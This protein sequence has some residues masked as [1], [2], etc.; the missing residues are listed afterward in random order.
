[1]HCCAAALSNQRRFI[2]PSDAHVKA[3]DAGVVTHSIADVVETRPAWAVANSLNL[4][5][6][7]RV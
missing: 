4:T 2:E 1:M 7:L 3:F 5:T 6:G